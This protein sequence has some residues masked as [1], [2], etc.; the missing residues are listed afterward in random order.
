MKYVLTD[1]GWVEESKSLVDS[2]EYMYHI[3][4]VYKGVK[5]KITP[6][7]PRFAK[8]NCENYST[9]RICVSPTIRQ[10]I[11][12]IDGIERMSNSSLEIGSSW[13]VYKTDKK[14]IPAK[15]ILDFDVTNEHWIKEETTFSYVGRIFR[16]SESDF[17]V[18]K[19]KK[20][21]LEFDEI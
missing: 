19:N 21:I 4:R 11:Q 2:V 12:G 5:A 20:I 9:K 1:N 14:G 15:K 7:I 6:K 10:C 3:S 16:F 18:F 13:Y 8:E 17:A